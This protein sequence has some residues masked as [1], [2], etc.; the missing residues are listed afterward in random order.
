TGTTGE[1]IDAV[2]GH[3]LEGAFVAGPVDHPDL[4]Q[5]TVFREELAIMTGPA[6][7]SLAELPGHSAL[8][9]VVLR[10]SCAYRQRLEAILARRGIVGLRCL[11]FGTL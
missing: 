9:I 4:D 10:A 6:V 5:R 7:R 3:H 1:L 2:L 11:E 8:K